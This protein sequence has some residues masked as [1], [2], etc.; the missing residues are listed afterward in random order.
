[1]KAIEARLLPTGETLRAKYETAFHASQ[2]NRA[3]FRL[4]ENPM[5]ACLTPMVGL[6]IN[7]SVL[8]KH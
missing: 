4:S 2:K 3:V 8:R 5:G 6:P 1:V 7:I